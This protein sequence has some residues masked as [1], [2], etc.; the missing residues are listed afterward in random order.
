MHTSL[1]SGLG[2]ALM[3]GHATML[4]SLIFNTRELPGSTATDRASGKCKPARD[5]LI[6]ASRL[7]FSSQWPGTRPEPVFRFKRA[8]P[9][10]LIRFDGSHGT[11]RGGRSGA[12]GARSRDDVV[13]L[14]AILTTHPPDPTLH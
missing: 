11:S 8:V 3:R 10:R 13:C 7:L 4:L 1:S 2:A 5:A 9:Q 14:S 6:T 12:R